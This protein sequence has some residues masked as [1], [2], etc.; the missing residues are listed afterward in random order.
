ML[1]RSLAFI[2]L[3]SSSRQ[4]ALRLFSSTVLVASQCVSSLCIS[5]R[6]TLLKAPMRFSIS[7]KSTWCPSNSGP[8][9][10]TN[11]VFPPMVIRQAPHI[12]VPSTIM[13]FND[14]SVGISYFLVSRQTNFIIMAGPIAKHLFTF[15]RLIT[16]STPSV[17]SPLRP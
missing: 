3:R 6:S 10:H 12:P 15:S 11:L 16:S 13:V 1:E 9:T 7:S 4:T 8:S 5:S 17:T 14:T 2:L